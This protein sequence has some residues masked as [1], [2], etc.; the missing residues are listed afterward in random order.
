M[1]TLE[2]TSS[3]PRLSCASSCPR[4]QSNHILVMH[5]KMRCIHCGHRLRDEADEPT[6]Y[7]VARAISILLD[8]EFH[9]HLVAHETVST[10]SQHQVVDQRRMEFHLRFNDKVC[11]SLRWFRSAQ[12]ARYQYL[13]RVKAKVIEAPTVPYDVTNVVRE[14]CKSN[15]NPGS[16]RMTEAV[17]HGSGRQFIR[18]EQSY[19]VD[20]EDR[21]L[22]SLV[23][24]AEFS[25]QVAS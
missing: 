23:L 2:V 4:C 21:H 12:D 16:L 1:N 18:L 22:P 3:T 10:G 14:L 20:D 24:R 6:F 7:V 25:W 19:S 9:N 15:T 8:F 11:C 5:N 13:N 17:V